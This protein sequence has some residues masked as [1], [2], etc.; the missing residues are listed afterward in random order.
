MGYKIYK[1]F[2]WKRI[3][4]KY[5]ILSKEESIIVG[6]EERNKKRGCADRAVTGGSCTDTDVCY[7]TWDCGRVKCCDFQGIRRKG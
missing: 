6:R 2:L 7:G 5:L 3:K 4:Y 1:F